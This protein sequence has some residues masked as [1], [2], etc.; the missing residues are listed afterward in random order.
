MTN[1]LKNP[2]EEKFRILKMTN[3]TIQAKLMSLQP[4]EAVMELLTA[5]GYIQIDGDIS[6]F[7]GDYFVILAMGAHI[8]E[9]ESMKLK[10]L[11]MSPEDRKK[12][13]LI[14]ERQREYKEKMKKDAEY[15]K[16][17][18]DHSMKDRAEKA[19]EPQKCSVGNKLNFG[20]NMVKFEPPAESRGG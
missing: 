10:M 7:V 1:I 20:A 12:Q 5:L 11:T 14:M 19:K 4:S 18:Q 16:T 8:I 6:S 15:K 2:Q 17:L 9:E 3:K 13:E